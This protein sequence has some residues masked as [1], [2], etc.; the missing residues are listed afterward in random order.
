MVEAVLVCQLV[1]G[2]LSSWA[3]AQYPFPM[4]A[5]GPAGGG[6]AGPGGLPLPPHG[7]HLPMPMPLPMHMPVRQPQ[8]PVVVMPYRSKASDRTFNQKKRRRPHYSTEESSSDSTSYEDSSSSAEFDFRRARGRRQRHKKK[9][10]V[11]TPVISY[12]TRSGR[13]VYQKKVKKENPAEW[14]GLGAGVER[15]CLGRAGACPGGAWACPGG[16]GSVSGRGEAGACPGN[17]HRASL[18][19]SFSMSSCSGASS[20]LSIRLNSCQHDKVTHHR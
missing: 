15:E 2:A 19:V 13:V 11:L 3:S 17:A 10:E 12:V 1:L 18:A 16:A 5:L 8:M 14:L 9:R 4:A 7:A 6:P 20:L